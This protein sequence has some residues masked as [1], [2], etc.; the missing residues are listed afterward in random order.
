MGKKKKEHHNPDAWKK[1]PNSSLLSEKN[2][3]NSSLFCLQ[4]TSHFI[5]L[6]FMFLSTWITCKIVNWAWSE[7]WS[8]D[9]TCRG[10]RS[11]LD[12]DGA[13]VVVFFVDLP[14]TAAAIVDLPTNGCDP[15]QFPVKVTRRWRVIVLPSDDIDALVKTIQVS[16]ALFS[17]LLQVVS[18]LWSLIRRGDGDG[19]KE[20]STRGTCHEKLVAWKTAAY[21]QVKGL[22][23]SSLSRGGSGQLFWHKYFLLV[24]KEN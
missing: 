2:L 9:K 12:G 7:G 6:W 16:E 14:L 13:V 19:R 22:E 18:E 8:P 3:L 11:R 20:G 5:F 21:G 1:E 15:I 24:E 17:F 4:I 23:W 10:L